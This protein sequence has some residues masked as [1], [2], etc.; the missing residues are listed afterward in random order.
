M[1]PHGNPR[2]EITELKLPEA[3]ARGQLQNKSSLTG[4]AARSVDPHTYAV[5]LT[6]FGDTSLPCFYLQFPL[7]PDWVSLSI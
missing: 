1:E 5:Q 6:G 4:A 7:P 3:S 2:A